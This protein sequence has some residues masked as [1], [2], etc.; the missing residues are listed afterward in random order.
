MTSKQLKDWI[1]AEAKR[2]G[3]SPA[4]IQRDFILGKLLEKISESSYKEN[5]VI[6]GGYVL[7][8]VLGIT[9]RTTEDLDT[10]IINRANSIETM[11]DFLEEVFKNPTPEGIEFKDFKIDNTREAANYPGFRIRGFAY[12]EKMRVPFRMD[13]TAGDAIIPSPVRFKHQLMFE[14]KTINVLAYPLEQILAE[15][16]QTVLSRGTSNSRGK[17]FYDLYAL[18]Q[19]FRINHHD[20]M[21]SFNATNV[22]R[23]TKFTQPQILQILTHMRVDPELNDMW[24][25]YRSMPENQYARDIEFDQIVNSIKKL[26]HSEQKTIGKVH[27]VTKKKER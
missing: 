7:Q 16:L 1:K 8:S 15:K 2:T 12:I 24:N 23:H 14:D 19:K 22:V 6:K 18:P 5:L 10:T 3:T 26:S 21:R 27:S 4:I 13:I 11:H 25:R 20:L 9:N 17:D